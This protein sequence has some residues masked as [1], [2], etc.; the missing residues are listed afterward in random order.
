MKQSTL[1]RNYMSMNCWNF[2]SNP[3]IFNKHS[4]LQKKRKQLFKKL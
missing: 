2:D 4:I 3:I 1:A